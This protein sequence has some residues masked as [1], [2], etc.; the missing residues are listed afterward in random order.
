M[1][2]PRDPLPARLTLA[3]LAHL[4]LLAWSMR[5]LGAPA[6]AAAVPQVES[7][8]VEVPSERPARR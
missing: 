5:A 4:L 3:A 8:V 6:P 2:N 7:A 1:R